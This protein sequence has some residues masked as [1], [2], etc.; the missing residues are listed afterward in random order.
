MKTHPLRVLEL[1]CLALLVGGEARAESARNPV[2]WADVP[3]VAAIRVG[4]T[5]YMASTT[6]HMSPGLPIMKSKD[7]IN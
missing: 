3:D 2:I 7:L 6:M 5:Y 1:T 4:D